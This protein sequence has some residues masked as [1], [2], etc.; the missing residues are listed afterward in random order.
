[1]VERI[2][3]I[4]RLHLLPIAPRLST[5]RAADSRR[6]TIYEIRSPRFHFSLF[7]HYSD[8]DV[9]LNH[10]KLSTDQLIYQLIYLFHRGRL[11]FLFE[12]LNRVIF[13]LHVINAFFLLHFK[14]IIWF[15]INY[16]FES[17]A[18]SYFNVV[19]IF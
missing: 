1:M 7:L 5:F 16:T 4:R 11:L 19:W 18:I 10:N 3:W 15:F 2:Q 12:F 8:Y 9:W 14:I 13:F 17:F 6:L